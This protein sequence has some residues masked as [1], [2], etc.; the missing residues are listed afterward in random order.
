MRKLLNILAI[1]TLTVTSVSTVVACNK[2]NSKSN[3][4]DKLDYF[5]KELDQ[6]KN[7]AYQE[8]VK[9]SLSIAKMLLSSRHENLN[10]YGQ[11]VLNWL[12]QSTPDK[13]TAKTNT[14]MD[15]SPVKKI[16]KKLN[17]RRQIPID[18]LFKWFDGENKESVWW[19][20][21]DT[22]ALS[23]Y[24]FHNDW[25]D[26]V[27]GYGNKSND[28]KIDSS[29][30][31]L[32]SLLYDQTKNNGFV[33]KEVLEYGNANNF[34]VSQLTKNFTNLYGLNTINLLGQ[35]L[36][37]MISNNAITGIAI[38]SKIF[39]L[40]PNNSFNGTYDTDLRKLLF[41]HL[42]SALFNLF[43]LESKTK[44]LFK[45]K[46]ES[47]L[48]DNYTKVI[49]PKIDMSVQESLDK[50]NGFATGF[51]LKPK[52]HMSEL[53]SFSFKKKNVYAEFGRL[54]DALQVA[55]K[56]TKDFDE[57]KFNEILNEMIFN[58][59][60]NK[61]DKL[62]NADV[63]A[64]LYDVLTCLVELFKNNKIEPLK[65]LGAFAEFGKMF[66][67]YEG[68]ENYSQTDQE[69]KNAEAL[70]AFADLSDKVDRKE[71]LGEFNFNDFADPKNG[72]NK[73]DFDKN[74]SEVTY[75]D[76]VLAK[77]GMSKDTSGSTV[78]AKDSMLDSM[79][80]WST[81]GPMYE[82]LNA[83]FK[84]STSTFTKWT[85]KANKNITDNYFDYLY[86]GNIWDID[87]SS[88]TLTTNASGE[89]FINYNIT[90]NGLGDELVNK[91]ENLEKYH[92]APL[93]YKLE[94]ALNE[95]TA[96]LGDQ[97]NPNYTNE[98]WINHDGTASNYINVKHTYKVS[99]SINPEEDIVNLAAF[100]WIHNGTRYY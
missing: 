65:L 66:G 69:K 40:V 86:R 55:I 47:V 18:T 32:Y 67:S 46:F 51:I 78:I 41:G 16:I 54:Y 98:D 45:E 24:L 36:S 7:K 91:P 6:I 11:S 58:N 43:G 28:A 74:G 96:A 5:D 29:R 73:F 49:D 17:S 33:T 97:K 76:W 77:M 81:D 57:T 63:Q 3:V 89:R 88:V 83:M 4:E 26:Q 80:K 20:Y 60:K 70:K 42:N 62:S 34:N 8:Y 21:S 31:Y 13:Y 64:S 12:L 85:N 48:K 37:L 92:T 99:F 10:I 19:A 30:T 71:P 90:Y 79:N 82:F 35:G 93:N 84:S 68:A 2:T 22:G 72:I 94:G 95:W 15:L 27:K 59:L 38:L 23:N 56:N 9:K 52:V 53:L 39:P 25:K 14:V 61:I 87:P 1:T 75:H 50:F 44:E 100:Q